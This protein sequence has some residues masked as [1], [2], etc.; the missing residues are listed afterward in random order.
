MQT[1]E[2]TVNRFFVPSLFLSQFSVM[3]PSILSGLLLIEIASTFNTSVGIAAQVRTT[4]STIS[5]IFAVFMGVLSVKVKHRTLMLAGAS[6]L[7]ISS[8]ICPISPSFI[9]FALAYSLVGFS[10]AFLGPIGMSLVGENLSAEKRGQ[11]ISWIISGA[12]LTYLIGAPVISRLS[13]YGGWRFSFLGYALPVVLITL[14]VFYIGIP[15]QREKIE[16]SSESVFTGFKAVLGN[17]SA[18]SCMVANALIVA[19]Y[20]AILYYG[21][22]FFRQSFEVSK[23]LASLIIVGGALIFVFGTQFAG[24]IVNIYGTKKVS[25]YPAL[26]GGIM[27]ISC[28]NVNNVWSSMI[29]RFLGSFFVALTYVASRSLTLEQVPSFRGTMMSLNSASQSLG[30]VIGTGV[31]GILLLNYSYQLVGIVLGLFGIISGLTYYF[32]TQE[33]EVS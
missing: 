5:M 6:L 19:S 15:E 32:F 16:S 30:A 31:G 18:I 21:S 20:Q 14:L 11:A 25:I 4:S 26:V 27:I 3:S 13:D 9:I 23:D 29:F 33:P 10:S 12:A 2:K 7:L 28:M 24:R 8:V 1:T 22:S 17:I